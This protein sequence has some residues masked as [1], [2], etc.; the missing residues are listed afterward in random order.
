MR[1]LIV[2]L[3]CLVSMTTFAIEFNT[4]RP[5]D[6]DHV[7]VTFSSVNNSSYMSVGSA[8]SSSV[9]EVGS[10]GPAHHGSV[11]RAGGPGSVTPE[12]PADVDPNN[13]QFSPVGDALLP[14]LLL[15]IGYVLI[16]RRND[17]MME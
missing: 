6:S 2:T 16:R 8:Y 11:H 15:A 14:L 4:A 5:Q 12:T 3:L 9:Y 1:K 17:E 10:S 7:D 13:P